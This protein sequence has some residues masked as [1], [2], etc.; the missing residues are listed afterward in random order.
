MVIKMH[1]KEK[2]NISSVYIHIPFCKNI[3]NYCDF[4]KV[5]YNKDLVDKYLEALEKEVSLCYNQDFIETIYVGGG[6]PSSLNKK[7]LDKLFLVINKLNID[8]LKEFTFEC[9]V[10]DITE[11]LLVYLK[12]NGVNRL[13]VGIESFNTRLLNVLGR[14]NSN[15]IE[16][17]KL[18]KKYFKNINIDLIYGINGQS[19]EE[20]KYDLDEFLKLD[21]S[22]ISI[23]SLILE[24]NTILKI[25]DYIEI[26]DDVSREMYDTIC[27]FLKQNN[28]THYEI[29]N[30]AKKGYESKH[31]LTYWHNKKYYGF[32]AGAA[33][34]VGNIRYV[35]TKSVYNYI[36]HNR[37]SEEIITDRI[38]MENFMILGLRLVSGVSNTDFKKRYQKE[39][40]DVFDIK[41]LDHDGDR[42]FIDE[43]DLY[44]SNYILEDFIDIEE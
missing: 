18:C 6:T 2:E 30:F 9:N 27:E 36:K 26:N 13:S 16:K 14:N 21:V 28:Y 10:N 42:Y 41:K 4:C 5:Y 40:A 31:N 12:S 44:I 3:C 19:V 23:Y 43:N 17:I 38:D 1:L 11:N 29:S 39:V 20:L 8:N 15:V 33:G 7:Q 35:N 32:G 34:Y 24:D 25:N 37:R 22:H